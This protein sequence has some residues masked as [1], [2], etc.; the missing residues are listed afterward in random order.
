M[1]HFSAPWKTAVISSTALAVLA[2]CAV[3]VGGVGYDGYDGGGYVGG[4]YEPGGYDYGGWGGHYHVG[5]PRGGYGR[6]GGHPEGGHP[7]GGHPEG[8]SGIPK[9]AVIPAPAVIRRAGGDRRPRSPAGL[10]VSGRRRSGR[11]A[12]K[13]QAPF[14]LDSRA[15]EC[16]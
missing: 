10:D 6:E 7:E 3:G 2:A 12:R 8:G 16:R 14:E 4:Y 5:P 11:Q 9:R 15:D 13:T 1:S